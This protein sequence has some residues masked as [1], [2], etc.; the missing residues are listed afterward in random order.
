MIS[1]SMLNPINKEEEKK[2]FFFDIQYNP[3][4]HYA[5]KFE[6]EELDAKYGMVSNEFLVES[7]RILSTVIKKWKTETAFLA[8]AEGSLMTKDQVTKQALEYFQKNGIESKVKIKFVSG[9]VSPGSMTGDTLNIRLPVAARSLRFEGTLNHEVGTH[10]FR[11]INEEQ[12]PWYE[13]REAFDLSFPLE[14]EEGLAVLHSHLHLEHKNMWFAALYYVA[15]YYANQM[16]FSALYEH[17]KQYIDDRDRRWNITL[18]AKRGMTDTSL[19]GAIGKDQIYIRGVMKVIAWLEE[20]EY[21]PTVL[22]FG[23]V[24]LEDVERVKAISP[25]FVPVLPAFLKEGKDQYKKWIQAIKKQ[26]EL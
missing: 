26:N 13:K 4:F 17:L 5:H 3:Q 9:Q 25:N 10:Y 21:D 1:I 16:T 7:E 14:T 11:R 22:Y 15:L 20:N 18:R 19:P 24:A 8:D 23:K 12:Q 2:K 6:R